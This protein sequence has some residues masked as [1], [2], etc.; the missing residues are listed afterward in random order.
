MDL[1]PIHMPTLMAKALINVP[2]KTKAIPAA[3]QALLPYLVEIQSPRKAAGTY[4]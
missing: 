1:P 2:T 4:R 3:I